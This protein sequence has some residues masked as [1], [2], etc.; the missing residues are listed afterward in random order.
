MSGQGRYALMGAGWALG[1]IV[2][3]LLW[4]LIT[5]YHLATAKGRAIDTGSHGDQWAVEDLTDR[6]LYGSTLWFGVLMTLVL[7][8]AFIM[9]LV[10]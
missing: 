6:F 5:A 4:P 8:L 3:Y 9:S 7:V 2:G 10:R 1:T